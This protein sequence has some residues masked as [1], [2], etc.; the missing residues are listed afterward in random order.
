MDKVKLRDNLFQKYFDVQDGVLVS[1]LTNKLSFIP[2]TWNKLHVLC[3]KNIKHFDRFCSLEKFKM[4][5]HNNKKYLILKLRM[6][7]YVI[8]DLD[9]ME[10]ISLDEFYSLFDEEFF[11]DNFG[12]V[13]D[14]LFDMYYVQKYNGDIQELVNFY[15]ENEC[16]F[17][18]SSEIYCRFNIDN[19]WTWLFIDFVN[20]QI[21][22]GFQ[23]CDQLLYEQLFLNY[24]LTPYG[25][26]DAKNKMGMDKMIEFFSKVNGISLPLENI[27]LDLYEVFLN[28]DNSLILKNR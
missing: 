1:D 4:I 8:I 27:P 20:A 9:M 24:D 19:A 5:E 12:E 14:N 26:Q 18:L 17:N 10:N 21:Q 13:K 11:V 2:D 23:T 3:Q 28:Y 7:R 6:W 16:V 15:I 22:M 25:M